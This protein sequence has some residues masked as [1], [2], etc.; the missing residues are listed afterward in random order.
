LGDTV[1]ELRKMARK[2]ELAGRSALGCGL[3]LALLI[4][5]GG[6]QA[7]FKS[8]HSFRGGN[9]GAGPTGSLIRN[10]AGDL[11]GTTRY[12]GGSGCNGGDG[13][14]VVFKLAPEG[15]E[16]V[17]HSF[18]G[19]NDGVYPNGGLVKDKKGNLY[20]TTPYGGGSGCNCGIVFKVAS[21]GTETI[22]YT[23]TGGSDG[24]QPNGS[25]FADKAGNFY[26][27]TIAGGYT[28]GLC[29]S[30]GCGTV[31]KLA[32][33]G[34][35][36]VLYSFTSGND[37]QSPNG[38]LIAD[39]SGNFYGTT[40]AGG[41]YDGGTIFKLAANGTETLLYAFDTNYLTGIGGPLAGV[42]RDG[43]GDLFTTVQGGL[44]GGGAVF[45]L[46]ADGTANVVYSFCAQAECSDGVSPV[47]NLILDKSGNLYGTA[48]GG[49]ANQDGVIFKLTPVGTE[50]V[51]H[52]FR[53]SDGSNPS[54]G[55]VFDGNRNLYGTAYSGGNDNDGT[56]YKKNK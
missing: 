33:D 13:C 21:D 54:G 5:I 45:E 50:T 41:P 2:L 37:G 8:L 44:Y 17:L 4:P 22:L 18:A 36:T 31:F 27:T 34:T 53:G 6:A 38:G 35:E 46:A 49:G 51:L 12:G 29:Y 7:S 1:G 16:L 15:K 55:L 26:G 30:F 9:K 25:L 23:F 3:A 40:E 56:V 32:P 48:G 42:T 11:F 39:M 10:K 52:S 28:G 20:G 43:A 14:G 19:G 24:G 47:S